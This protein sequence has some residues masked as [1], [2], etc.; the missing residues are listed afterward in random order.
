MKLRIRSQLLLGFGTML[1]LVAVVSAV[2][3]SQAGALNDRGSLLYD[4]NLVSSG[5]I[6]ELGRL[7]MQ[8]RASE[9]EHVLASAAPACAG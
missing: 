3:I 9:L 4:Q 1:V 2:G 6:A 8:D 7:T 5:H